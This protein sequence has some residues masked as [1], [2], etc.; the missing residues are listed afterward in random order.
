MPL[1]QDR[2]STMS[3]GTFL[4]EIMQLLHTATNYSIHE[5][6]IYGC[7]IS[8][9]VRGCLFFSIQI[10]QLNILIAALDNVKVKI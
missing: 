8:S 1:S 3:T 5:Q 6:L 9:T 4:N 2:H 7:F 10:F